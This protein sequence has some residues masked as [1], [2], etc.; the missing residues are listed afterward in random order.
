MRERIMLVTALMLL[1]TAAATVAGD[2]PPSIVAQGVP[3]VTREL[4]AQIGRYQNARSASFFGWLGG[5]REVLIGTRFADTNQ[6]HWVAFPGGTRAQ[7]T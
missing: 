2:V 7:L 4:K 5:R 1:L 3:G 6:V